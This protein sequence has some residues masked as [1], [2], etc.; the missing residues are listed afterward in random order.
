MA[1]VCEK[2]IVKMEKVLNICIED[3]KIDRKMLHQKAFG[4]A[5]NILLIVTPNHLLQLK[6]GYSDLELNLYL[7]NVKII[8]KIEF[9]HKEFADEKVEIF[10]CDKNG[11]F[12]IFYEIR[13]RTK[14]EK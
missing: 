1:V 3:K 2:C 5:R 9:I 11:I 12:F 6:D 4:L 10:T 8:R 13:L 14:S 7:R